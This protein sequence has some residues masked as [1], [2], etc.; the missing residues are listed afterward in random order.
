M[1][2]LKGV[3]KDCENIIIDKKIVIYNIL[4]HYK[5]EEE[6]NNNYLREHTKIIRLNK[7][8]RI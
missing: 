6:I 2:R 4:G 5:Y 7:K 8:I 3:I 1:G